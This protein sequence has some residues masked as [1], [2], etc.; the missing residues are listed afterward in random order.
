MEKIILMLGNYCW[1][2]FDIKNFYFF[3]FSNLIDLENIERNNK[4]LFLINW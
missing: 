4:F 2:D 3:F 1:E